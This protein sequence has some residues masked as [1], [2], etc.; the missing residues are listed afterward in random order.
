MSRAARRGS[1]RRARARRA[2]GARRPPPARPRSPSRR[3]S[4]A[5][6][7]PRRR[8][9]AHGSR[10][11]R[12]PS[13]AP[14]AAACPAGPPV[15]ASRA[16][17]TRRPAWRRVARIAAVAVGSRGRGR[18]RLGA[19]R[20]RP[21]RDGAALHAGRLRL[22]AHL[23]ARGRGAARAPARAHRRGVEGPDPAREPSDRVPDAD[24]GRR[25]LL[26]RHGRGAGRRRGLRHLPPRGL[27]APRSRAARVPGDAPARRRLHVHDQERLARRGRQARRVR[28]RQGALLDRAARHGSRGSACRISTRR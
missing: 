14:R 12:R 27:L 5:R 15:V 3:A 2:R 23:R 6:R 21:E 8:A 26:P 1:G 4:R 16:V 25:A 17:R 13:R 9:R 19:A 28:G 11:L 7:A 22:A 20:A 18:A 10:G 24:S